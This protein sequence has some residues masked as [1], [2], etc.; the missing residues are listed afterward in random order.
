MRLV[1]PGAGDGSQWGDEEGV[2][3]ARVRILT[4][5]R[6]GA[7]ILTAAYTVRKEHAPL[8]Q[9]LDDLQ[10]ERSRLQGALTQMD[11]L[12]PGSLVARFRKCGKPTCHCAKPDSPGHG[13]SYSLTRE[14][15]SKTVTKIIPPSAVEQTQRQIAECKR[16]RDL[17][18]D[19]VEV[20]EK[21]CDAQLHAPTDSAGREV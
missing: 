10:R 1:I 21:V 19:F 2:H 7:T 4:V 9:S 5:A 8:P 12:R 17:T 13:P 15:E 3:D 18:R 11:D 14:V 16:F 6:N 20:S